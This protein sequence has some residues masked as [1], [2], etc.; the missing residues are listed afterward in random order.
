[1]TDSVAFLCVAVVVLTLTLAMTLMMVPV[2][3]WRVLRQADQIA[4]LEAQATK[5][6]GVGEQLR[7]D[8][9]KV[10]LV[11]DGILQGRRVQE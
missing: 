6:A 9:D 3:L 7:H 1:M 11:L 4:L 10:D 2:L 5:L 8:L